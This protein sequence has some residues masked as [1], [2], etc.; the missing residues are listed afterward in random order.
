MANL[1]DSALP[2]LSQGFDEFMNIVLDDAEEVWVKDTKT[3]KTGD[4]QQLGAFALPLSPRCQADSLS[5]GDRPATAQGGEHHAHQSG[6]EPEG[7]NG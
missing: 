7:M 6:A 1:T 3:K 5:R 2:E 4:R